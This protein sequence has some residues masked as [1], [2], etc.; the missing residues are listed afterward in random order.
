MLG[1]WGAATPWLAAP[2]DLSYDLLHGL[3]Q[4]SNWLASLPAALQSNS[5]PDWLAALYY[6]LLVAVALFGLHRM[7]WSPLREMVSRQREVL[8]ALIAGAALL[9]VDL[10]RADVGPQA[11]L[12]WSG[13]GGGMVL[14]SQGK[15][16][17][18]D[19]SSRP[20][21]YLQWLGSV[22]PQHDRV[23][24]LVMVTDP[25]ARSVM[26]LSAVLRHYRVLSV[27]D[28]GAQYPSASY[29]TWRASLRQAKTPIFAL[30]T[31]S[32]VRV[33][34]AQ[35]SAVGPDSLCP[36]PSNCTGML[37]ISSAH[38]STVLVG[39]ASVREQE[40]AVFRPIHLRADVVL[41]EGSGPL[42]SDFSAAVGARQSHH[43]LVPS[44]SR[45]RAP[46]TTHWLNL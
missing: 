25:R 17:L 35:V 7:N 32:T 40:E 20:L 33:G 4:F 1:I 38:R 44:A 24:D 6:C 31:G 29:A 26:G 27:W 5:F 43:V 28:V 45:T 16:A 11:R 14:R 9:T 36:N 8:L 10:A 21:A 12:Y 19:G 22:L 39:T 30:R 42:S 15:T 18:I 13:V 23:I 37:R 34:A 46:A 2:A 3:I 41:W